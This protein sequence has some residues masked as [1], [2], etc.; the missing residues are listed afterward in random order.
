MKTL[1]KKKKILNNTFK[2]PLQDV[3]FHHHKSIN[4]SQAE[5]PPVGSEGGVVGGEG[6]QGFV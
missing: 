6:S 1:Q 4:I 3:I 5:D 2:F